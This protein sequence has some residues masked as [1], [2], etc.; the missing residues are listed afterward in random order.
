MKTQT[1]YLPDFA[2]IDLNWLW[3]THIAVTHMQVCGPAIILQAQTGLPVQLLC[4]VTGISRAL[5][6][7]VLIVFLQ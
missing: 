7:K 6:G 5:Q 2:E 4:G 3:K 1:I